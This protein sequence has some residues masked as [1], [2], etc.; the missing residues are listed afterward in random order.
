MLMV[1][2]CVAPLLAARLPLVAGAS[3]AAWLFACKDS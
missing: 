2:L 3:L 1:S